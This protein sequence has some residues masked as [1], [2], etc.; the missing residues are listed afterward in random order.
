MNGGRGCLLVV[1]TNGEWIARDVSECLEGAAEQLG[2]S[3]GAT[4]NSVIEAI[5]AGCLPDLLSEAIEAAEALFAGEQEQAE[6]AE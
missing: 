5:G 6:A 4:W 3:N 1:T 2:F